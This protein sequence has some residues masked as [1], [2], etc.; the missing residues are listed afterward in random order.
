MYVYFTSEKFSILKLMDIVY[1]NMNLLM[2]D[3]IYFSSIVVYEY[4]NT[5]C[6]P[7]AV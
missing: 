3:L 1:S 7:Q 4:K 5:H 2:R 6:L